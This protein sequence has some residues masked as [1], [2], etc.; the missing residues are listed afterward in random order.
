[1]PFRSPVNATRISGLLQYVDEVTG[2]W[3][4]NLVIFAIFI[5]AF[6]AMLNRPVKEAFTVASFITTIMA[7][8]FFFLGIL[9]E[10][11]LFIFIFATAIGVISL[12][13]E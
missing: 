5:I 12:L 13:R 7:S 1:M 11:V 6:A 3:F 8:L 2:Y 9:N 10:L 4:G